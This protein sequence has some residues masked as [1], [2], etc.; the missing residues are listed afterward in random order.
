MSSWIPDFLA[1]CKGNDVP[2]DFVSTHEYPTDPPG[3]QTRTFFIDKLQATRDTVGNIPLCYTEYDD[4]YNDATSYSAAFVIYQNFLANGVVDVLSFW[5]F[6]DIFEEGGLY[7]QPYSTTWMP[8]D[9]LMNVYG[10]PKPNYRAFQLLHWT[11][12]TLVETTPNTFHND[13]ETVGVFA[14]TG[15]N[16]SIF[17]VNWNVM[18]QPIKQET[19]S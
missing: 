10:V 4:G 17:I 9:G 1:F 2:F 5:L 12:S 8:V 15:S 19:V 13:N 7:P 18:H 16:T 3:P 11:G 14:V 6:S